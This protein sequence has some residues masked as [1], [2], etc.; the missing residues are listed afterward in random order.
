MR[1]HKNLH[2]KKTPHSDIRPKL[3]GLVAHLNLNDSNMKTIENGELF[4]F[5]RQPSRLKKEHIENVNSLIS[6]VLCS[7]RVDFLDVFIEDSDLLNELI[8]G[9]KKDLKFEASCAWVSLP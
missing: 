6:G 4:I 7:I 9:I 3:T 1:S 8:I 5:G 2:K